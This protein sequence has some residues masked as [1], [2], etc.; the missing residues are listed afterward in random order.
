MNRLIP[1]LASTLLCLFTA[2]SSNTVFDDEHTFDR[3]V[4]NRFTPEVYELNINN[5]EDYYNIDF[6]VA[7]DTTVYRYDEVPVIIELKAPGGE[8]RQF[9]G[10]VVLREK[11]RW[12]GEMSDGFR[13]VTGRIRNYFSFN[14][15]GR[16]QMEVRH[17]T[18]QYDLEGIH[19]LKVTVTRAKIDY[20]L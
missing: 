20:N 15:K 17:T 2:C 5:I 11:G 16:H 18:S 9:Y 6:T 4:W 7:V 3:N 12:R 10:H 1:I 14:A 13:V 19:S 8:Q